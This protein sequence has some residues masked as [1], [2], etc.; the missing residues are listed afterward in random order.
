MLNRGTHPKK[1]SAV[2]ALGLEAMGDVEVAEKE[3]LNWQRGGSLP[4]QWV[5]SCRATKSRDDEQAFP[6]NQP[7]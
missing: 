2:F 1:S 5:Q 7:Q 3:P 4:G 6:T